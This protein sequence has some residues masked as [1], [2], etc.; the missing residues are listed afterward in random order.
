LA[1]R[2]QK[3]KVGLF[4]ITC[5]LLIIGGVVLVTGLKYEPRITYYVEF[6]E[7]VLGL[8]SGGL[9]EYMGVPVGNV[10]D[11]VVRPGRTTGTPVAFVTI[12]V[13]ENKVTL[14]QGVQA[15]LVL[16]SLATGT[17]AVSLAGGDPS[18][19][20]LPAGSLIPSKSSLVAAVSSRIETIL[21]DLSDIIGVV[22]KGLDGMKEGDLN[23]VV[24][25][26]NKLL[27]SGEE[28]VNQAN[29]LLT[30]L[31]DDAKSG[32][33]NFNSITKDLRELVGNTND[34][35]QT[36]RKQLDALNVSKTSENVNKVLDSVNNLA[37]RLQ[38]TA[39]VIE[40]LAKTAQGTTG[41]M[42]YNFRQTMRTLNESLNSIRDLADYL[43]RDPSALLRGK[44]TP[45]E[46]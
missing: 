7:S 5:T 23:A 2:K 12:E 14:Y 18:L 46:K 29:E 1:T 35:V 21:D 31:G 24:E 33:Q 22:K 15:Q 41:N 43:Q 28:F 42:E 32:V 10:A 11:I 38:D 13:I 20:V 45:G 4:L 27:T 36:L 40:G 44:G 26:A 34:A 25:R 37:E 19:G 17:M 30:D 3:A 16:Y 6:A 8:S 39:E 9:V